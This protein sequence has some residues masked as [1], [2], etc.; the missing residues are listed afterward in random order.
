MWFSAEGFLCAFASLFLLYCICFYYDYVNKR[1]FFL[2][3]FCFLS[4]LG[5]VY[6]FVIFVIIRI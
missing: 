4:R 2:F 6:N 5:I 1:V 3:F